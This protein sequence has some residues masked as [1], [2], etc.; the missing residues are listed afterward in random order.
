MDMNLPRVLILN[1][2]FNQ[3]TGGGITISNLFTGWPKEN[4]AVLC[5]STFINSNT[6]TTICETYYQ[7]GCE[8]YVFKF[9]FNLFKRK[10][11]SG[12]LKIE[13]E[14]LQDVS[15][16]A[17]SFRATLVNDYV[18]PFLKWA[19]IQ[20]TITKIRLSPQLKDWLDAYKPDI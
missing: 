17:S 8:E 20:N 12:Y 18:N 1:Q 5:S 16:T 11:N 15:L 7:L 13:N 10:Y 4:L 9:P 19:G 6:N 3:H 2:P 14:N